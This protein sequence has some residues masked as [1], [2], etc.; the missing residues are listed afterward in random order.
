MSCIQKRVSIFYMS[1]GAGAAFFL[2][3]G[4]LTCWVLN[5]YSQ[6]RSGEII[7]ISFGAGVLGTP[8]G[9]G[10]GA[11]VY[12]LLDKLCESLSRCLQLCHRHQ[13]L[14]GSPG[15]LLAFSNTEGIQ[16]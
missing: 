9:C 10:F 14:G 7:A 1:T 16:I 4:S 3:L 5:V 15:E 11:L 12:W 13:G 8:F 6:M 2:G